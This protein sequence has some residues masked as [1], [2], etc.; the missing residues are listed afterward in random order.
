MTEL[1]L[2]CT[3]ADTDKNRRRPDIVCIWGGVRYVIDIT[4]AWKTAVG[5]V[6]ERDVGH[7]ADKKAAD[8]ERKYKAAMKRQLRGLPGWLANVRLEEVDQFV[9]LAYEACGSWGQHAMDF[10]NFVKRCAGSEGTRAAELYHWSAMTFGGHWRRRMA[11]EI[12]RGRV[13]CLRRS[14]DRGFEGNSS[15]EA[16][17]AFDS[18]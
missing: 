4:I 3:A 13:A 7:D 16:E 17:T 18:M 8:K 1:L 14:G 5:H 11:V 12:G 15:S 9:P 10:F 6:T 2:Y